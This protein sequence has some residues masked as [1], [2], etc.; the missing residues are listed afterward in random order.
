MLCQIGLRQN[1]KRNSAVTFALYHA[2]MAPRTS[3]LWKSNGKLLRT[4]LKFK[5]QPKPN[6]DNSQWLTV[7]STPV[8]CIWVPF[9]R[10][11]R[12]GPRAQRFG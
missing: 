6:L 2:G 3:M 1:G 10:K 7:G 11:L 8:Y 4:P 5:P 9:N 12:F